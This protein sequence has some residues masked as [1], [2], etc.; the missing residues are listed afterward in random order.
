MA[1]KKSSKINDLHKDITSLMRQVTRRVN[2]M[3]KMGGKNAVEVPEL[4]HPSSV[5][6]AKQV[7]FQAE[8][9]LRRTS[10]NASVRKGGERGRRIKVEREYKSSPEFKVRKSLG[11]INEKLSEF[12]DNALGNSRGFRKLVN[13]MASYGIII[14][15]NQANMDL[16]RVDRKDFS[17]MI[18][19]LNE[20]SEDMGNVEQALRAKDSENARFRAQIGN[21]IG[22]DL[23]LTDGELN[24][25]RVALGR[26]EKSEQFNQGN[27]DEVVEI[28][29]K[30]KSEFGSF[31]YD[32]LLEAVGIVNEETAE[33]ER[34]NRNLEDIA[35]G[36]K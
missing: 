24:S 20:I 22:E 3:E 13:V 28:A 27:S 1:R 16:S 18:K 9:F 15:M 11:K 26:I 4:R 6:E 10:T 2:Q 36:G 12:Q 5:K 34:V 35:R 19:E 33:M 21:A 17:K 14:N 32:M 30:L 7:I 25:V 29:A 31:T 8:S 23:D